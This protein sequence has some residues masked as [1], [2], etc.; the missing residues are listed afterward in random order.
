MKI[1]PLPAA[2]LTSLTLM[3][4]AVISHWMGVDESI[5]LA[6]LRAGQ[7]P[8][9][10]A[11]EQAGD[12]SLPEPRFVVAGKL[13]SPPPTISEPAL[14]PEFGQRMVLALEGFEQ[15]QR[16]NRNLRDQVAETNRDLM[17]LQFRVDSHS[18]SFRPL[19]AVQETR[20]PVGPGVL[21]PIESP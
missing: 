3:T 15:L 7:P 6:R 18:Q 11:A 13:N 2:C 1:D 16:E 5:E 21:P 10:L 12:H 19:R 8:A 17:E 4:G 20:Q 9:Q 14:P